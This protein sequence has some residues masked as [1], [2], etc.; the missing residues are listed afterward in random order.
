M[1]R[2]RGADDYESPVEAQ[3]SLHRA[4]CVAVR[5]RGEND[6]RAAQLLQFRR[7]VLRLAVD[8]VPRSQ[9]PRQRFLVRPA[10]DADG[11][12]THLHRILHAEMTEAAE[13]QHRDNVAW[14]RAAV[15]QRVV[16]RDAR[17]HQRRGFHGGQILRHQRQREGGSHHVIRIT[18]V[19]GNAGYL[20]RH[21]ATKEIAAAAGIAMTT[22][23]AMP[24][25]AHALA[26][27]PLRDTRAHGIHDPDD[28]MAR[29]ARILQAR[30]VTF[31]D[32]RIA[33][34]DATG[35]DFH[36]HP[37]GAR[38]GNFTFNDFK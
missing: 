6:L 32:Q 36:P 31:L 17:A 27:F 24:A 33:V 5:H 12:E 14:T 15:P 1:Q 9:F 34:A 16:S 19:E 4:H 20:E 26:R 22:M 30:P 38:L 8:V 21:L 18:A 10:R 37:A 23:T 2:L 3:A 11:L 35:L 25:N 13:A 29:H 28:F 7:R